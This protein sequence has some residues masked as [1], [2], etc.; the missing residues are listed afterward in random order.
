MLPAFDPGALLSRTY[1][2]PR[3]P[4]VR[5]RLARPSDGPAI[6]ALAAEHGMEGDS[7]QVVRFDPRRLVICAMALVGAEEVF[8]GV[9]AIDLEPGAEPELV[10]VDEELTDGLVELL[11]AALAGRA[12]ALTRF[13]AA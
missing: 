13:R 5:L 2:L 12:G 6:R 7:L 4:R 11:T 8:A 10:L 3:G 1:V 9:G